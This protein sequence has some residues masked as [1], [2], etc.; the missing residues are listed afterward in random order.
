[1]HTAHFHLERILLTW[2]VQYPLRLKCPSEL[3]IF[4]FRMEGLGKLHFSPGD[5]LLFLPL[6][7]NLFQFFTLIH[8]TFDK[9]MK[10]LDIF[11][12]QKYQNF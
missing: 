5:F 6:N 7:L 4:A 11:E 8:S 2:S 9:F 3:R 12:I 1:M 10:H